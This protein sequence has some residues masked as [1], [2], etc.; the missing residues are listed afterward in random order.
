MKITSKLILALV[1]ALA[2]ASCGNQADEE[3]GYENGRCVGGDNCD[4]RSLEACYETMN[5]EWRYY[6]E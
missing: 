1:A 5:C 6:S 2:L 3:P 4:G